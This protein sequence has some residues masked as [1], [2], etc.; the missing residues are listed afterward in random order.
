MAFTTPT[1]THTFHNADGSGASG[2]ITFALTARMT[3]GTISLVPSEISSNLTS[4]G[5]LSQPLTSNLDSGTNP[6]GANWRVD[7]RISGAESETFYITVPAILSETAGSTTL[8]SQTVGVSA[9]TAA[10]AIV[11]QSIT[12]TNIPTATVITAIST[13]ANTLTISNAATGT[14]SG[15]SFT[16]GSTIDL[17]YLLPGQQ[18]VG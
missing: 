16:I 17:G 3:N 1:V 15:L 9:A 18:Q 13:S 11:G 5:A 2:T 8:S 14:G 10:A 6:T 4:A 7:F 12:G